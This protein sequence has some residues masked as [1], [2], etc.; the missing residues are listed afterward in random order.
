MPRSTALTWK[1]VWSR[2]LSRHG[3]ATPA[4]ADG[5]AEQVA[6]ICGAHAQVMSAAEVSI[7]IRVSG[8]TRA[9]VRRAL[10]DERSLVKTIGP[11]GTVHLLPAADLAMWNAVL[12]AS[13][14]PPSFPARRAARRGEDRR[15]RRGH[16]RGVGRR[17][18]DARG[19]RRRGPAAGRRVGGRAGDAGVPGAVAAVA[20]GDPSGCQSRRAVLRAEPR[21]DA[22]VLEPAPVGRRLPAVPLRR[23]RRARPCVDICTHTGL[24]DRSTSRG[25]S[26]ARP[27]G[28]G[29]RSR[30][31]VTRSSVSRSRATSCGSSPATRF[32]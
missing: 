9:D 14:Q 16:R 29:T 5:M 19:A 3:L 28:P 21:P 17:G 11:R 32:R 24:R 25:G 18:S 4:P 20:P 30:K 2:R 8:I 31:R 10:W 1:Q 13:L 22:D 6:A 23:R 15:R 26:A 27:A 12:D 7:G